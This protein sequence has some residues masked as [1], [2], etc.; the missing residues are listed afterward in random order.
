MWGKRWG[1]ASA[2][3]KGI[4][5]GKPQRANE[6]SSLN[7]AICHLNFF[8]GSY[9]SMVDPHP[10]SFPGNLEAAAVGSRLG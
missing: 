10:A 5:N 7:F 1:D 4:S 3:L 2:E 6:V 8:W 9:V